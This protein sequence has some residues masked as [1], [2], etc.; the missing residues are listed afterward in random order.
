VEVRPLLNHK[1]GWLWSREYHGISVVLVD[2]VDHGITS[3]KLWC[4]LCMLHGPKEIPEKKTF[5]LAEIHRGMI[6]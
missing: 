5:Y 1:H 2:Q 6:G 3:V 4:M